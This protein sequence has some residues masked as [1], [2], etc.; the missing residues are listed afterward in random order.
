MGKNILAS[1]PAEANQPNKVPCGL[2][3]ITGNNEAK[4]KV[5]SELFPYKLCHWKFGISYSLKKGPA[6]LCD[7]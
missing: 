1:D 2:R 5:S 7:Q 6:S 3:P 4:K